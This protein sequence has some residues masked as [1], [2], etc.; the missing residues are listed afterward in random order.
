MCLKVEFEFGTLVKKQSN[1]MTNSEGS[2]LHRGEWL[3]VRSSNARE[4]G[5][6]C[7]PIWRRM[8]Q[9]MEESDAEDMSTLRNSLRVRD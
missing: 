6:R 3:R 2:A 5:L 8:D 4:E 7:K 1:K 9:R